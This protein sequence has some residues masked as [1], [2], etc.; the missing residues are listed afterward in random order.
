MTQAAK[1][2][3]DGECSVV[4]ISR[5]S[6]CE[7]CHEGKTAAC[8]ACGIFVSSRKASARAE[9]GIGAKVGDIVEVESRDGTILGFAALVFILPV[10]IPLLTYL[11]FR[12]NMTVAVIVSAAAFI[13]SAVAVYFI[14][15]LLD[16]RKPVL[17]ITKILK[18]RGDTEDFSERDARQR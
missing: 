8:A 2:V 17:I 12:H 1:V 18:S 14:S 6:A 7:M 11:I 3:K 9:N 15:K 16:R 13:L 10:A 5:K 4:E